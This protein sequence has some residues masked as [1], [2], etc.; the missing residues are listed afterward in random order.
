MRRFF[1]KNAIILIVSVIIAMGV[2][3]RAY[4]FSDWLHFELDQSRDAK[5]VDLAIKDGI[6]NLPLLGPKAA[7]SFLRLGPAF[8]YF[9]YLSALIFGNTPAGIATVISLFGILAIPV[10]YL[11]IRRYFNN[12]IAIGLLLLF[13][14]SIFLTMYSRFA[15]NPNP[16]PLFTILAFYALLRA[17]DANMKKRGVWLVISAAS[18]AIATQ[19]HFLAF[20]SIP[21]VF[22]IFLIIKRP[23]IKITYW[24]LSLAAVFVLYSP[25]IINE[26]KTGGE[27]AK[28]FVKEVSGKSGNGGQTLLEKAVRNYTENSL[29]HFLIL[30]GQSGAELPKFKV[31]Q[32]VSSSDIIC[33]GGCRKA[34]P[35]G[36]LALALFT[37]GAILLF[38][39]VLAENETRKK[40]FLILVALWFLATFA[41]FTPISSDISPR[42]FL[43]VSAIPFV[44]LGF[45]LKFIRRFLRKTGFKNYAVFAIILLLALSN[46]LA[47]KKR[48]GELNDA[49]SKAFKI[50]TDKILKERTRV[51]LA[52]QYNI[53]NYIENIYSENKYPV[54]INS[55]PYYRRS[56]LYHL[57]QRGTPRDDFR[58]STNSKRVYEHGNYFLIYPTLSNLDSEID[59]YLNNYEIVGKKEFG[60]LVIIRLAPKIEAINATEQQFK[61]EGKPK[62]APGVPVRCRWNEIF[63]KCNSDSSDETE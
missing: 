34:L 53:I 30:S 62:S 20:V 39:N 45:I 48:F 8:Y 6:G 58:N 28:E 14:T 54:Y 56:F 12:K 26:I 57:E 13:S 33:D 42:F 50:E 24:I 17:V 9:E 35:L 23:R 60:T 44:F 18:L 1:S 15:W 37:I 19:F 27:N 10:F 2:F 49:P 29:G 21:L 40:D 63:G 43:L 4:H 36:A 59:N 11:F 52:Q 31:G 47:I 25:M 38:K 61:P 22:V 32:S 51:T 3:L 16:L 46:G 55:E 7:G 5:V 41:L